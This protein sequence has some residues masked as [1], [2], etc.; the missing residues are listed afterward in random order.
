MKSET[1]LI[2]RQHLHDI[3]TN[4][5]ARILQVLR[6]PEPISRQ[7]LADRLD[8]TPASLSR[9]S[10][11]LIAD[12]IC[13]EAP[14]VRDSNQRGRPGVALR[15]HAQGGYL[16]AVS[17][18][19]YS[20]LISI[21]DISGTQH[22]Q[23]IIPV[24]VTAS[25]PN[26]VEFIG[27]Y[28]DQLVADNLLDG[29]LILGATVTIPGSISVES[30][31]LTKSVLLNWPNF[32]IQKQFS[33][34]LRCRVRVEN[35]GDALCRHF[36]DKHLGLKSQHASVFLAHISQSMGASIA[37]GG[38]IVRRLADEGW[39]NDIKVSVPSSNTESE[40]TLSELAS[41]GAILRDVSKLDKDVR[42]NGTE[43][44]QMIQSAVACSNRNAGPVSSVFFDSGYA[45]GSNLVPLTI[46][47]AP[48]VI[49]LAGPVLQAQAY[50][51]G[52]I[53]GYEKAAS[54]MDMQPS[55]IIVSGASYSDAS[56]NL[57]LHDFFLTGAYGI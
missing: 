27:A 42:K 30:G 39:I 36:M 53:A 34:R 9:I 1:P 12:G 15:I 28:I 54:E 18:S 26:T 43:F 13:V 29:R 48:E 57:A 19:S 46:A 6:E 4:N 20:R 38:R 52:V 8:L 49:V 14:L 35:N 5:R 47:I 22:H 7:E 45:L 56:E 2:K 32:P 3:R 55:K 50:S 40:Q 25:G 41:G 24:D 17:I 21:V 51:N 44:S 10:K 37:I 16:I 23:K 31:F 33:E 11:E